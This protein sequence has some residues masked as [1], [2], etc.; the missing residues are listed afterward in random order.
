[1]N[2]EVRKDW[3]YTWDEIETLVNEGYSCVR[4]NL[5]GEYSFTF[6]P[7]SCGD[8]E[9]FE[10]YLEDFT[11]GYNCTWVDIRYVEGNAIVEFEEKAEPSY[12]T[13]DM[14]KFVGFCKRLVEAINTVYLPLFM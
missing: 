3:C 6:E 10:I 2:L 13:D 9:H 4:E 11:N 7:V 5:E 8:I 14:Y 1:M 12:Y